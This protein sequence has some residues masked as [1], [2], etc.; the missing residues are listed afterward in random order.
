MTCCEKKTVSSA[1]DLDRKRKETPKPATVRLWV[2]AV[3]LSKKREA[4]LFPAEPTSDSHE[5]ALC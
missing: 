2:V 3:L 4:L 5:S 1:S